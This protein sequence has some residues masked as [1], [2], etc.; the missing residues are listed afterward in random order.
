MDVDSKGAS[1]DYFWTANKQEVEVTPH[2]KKGEKYWQSGSGRE[3]F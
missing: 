1:D 3:G 2:R